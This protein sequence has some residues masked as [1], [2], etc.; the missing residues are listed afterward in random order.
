MDLMSCVNCGSYSFTVLRDKATGAIKLECT[1][2]DVPIGIVNAE[3]NVLD[4]D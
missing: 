3:P 4:V 2:C 1:Q